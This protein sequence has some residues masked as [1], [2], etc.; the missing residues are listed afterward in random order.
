MTAILDIG[1][2]FA[3]TDQSDRPFHYLAPNESLEA[4]EPTRLTMTHIRRQ[5]WM[6]TSRS[7]F[8]DEMGWPIHRQCEI[9]RLFAIAAG[10]EE[11]IN[12]FDCSFLE[13]ATIDFH[14]EV[15]MSVSSIDQAIN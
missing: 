15:K 3:L 8:D 14:R 1:F 5:G 4:T 13:I 11:K 9:F 12:T 7:R 6:H 10:A 2:L